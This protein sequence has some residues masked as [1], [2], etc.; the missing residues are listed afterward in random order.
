MRA[1]GFISNR[2]F[3]ALACERP[4]VSD[5]IAGIPSDIIEGVTFFSDENPF[6]MAIQ[7]AR[8]LSTQGQEVLHKVAEVVRTKHSFESRSEKI[9]QIMSAK[10]ARA[11]KHTATSAVTGVC[12]SASNQ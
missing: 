4:V 10:L 5:E 1:S 7:Q 11:R 12:P 9:L 6:D 3:D 8:T 2:I